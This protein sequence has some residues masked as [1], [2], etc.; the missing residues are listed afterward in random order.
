MVSTRFATGLLG[1]LRLHHFQIDGSLQ[2]LFTCLGE[3]GTAAA[4]TAHHFFNQG[5]ASQIAQDVDG[6]PGG[7]VADT[8]PTCCLGNRA[9]VLQTT[10]DVDAFVRL[11]V[12][13]GFP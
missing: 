10:Q 2:Q 11:A 7:F 8:R 5:G 3:L 12:A 13:E 1:E 4:C 9:S 6:L